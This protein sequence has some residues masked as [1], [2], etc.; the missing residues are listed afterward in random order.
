MSVKHDIGN[1][2]V[3]RLGADNFASAAAVLM[4]AAVVLS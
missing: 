2:S 3:R 1:S 4:P